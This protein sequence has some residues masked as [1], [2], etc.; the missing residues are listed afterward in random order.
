MV[1]R[2][3]AECRLGRMSANFRYIRMSLLANMLTGIAN[4]AHG[5]IILKEVV[6]YAASSFQKRD[7]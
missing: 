7:I 2:M 6:W 3:S 5:L 1:A 4:D